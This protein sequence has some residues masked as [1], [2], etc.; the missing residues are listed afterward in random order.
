MEC[1]LQ[2]N[3]AK[4]ELIVI[5]AKPISWPQYHCSAGV[6]NTNT[7]QD[8]KEPGGCFHQGNQTLLV[9]IIISRL[10]YCNALLSLCRRS[11]ISQREPM[12]HPS[13]FHSTVSQLWP[14]SNIR[15]W[16]LP[17]GLALKLQLL[18]LWPLLPVTVTQQ[19]APCS[20]TTRH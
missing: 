6:Y 7:N 13:L 18:Q 11:R 19:A 12:S 10:D 2:L 3:L 4:T 20:F 15:L 16:R 9:R 5:L 1:N 17:S 14:E 8:N